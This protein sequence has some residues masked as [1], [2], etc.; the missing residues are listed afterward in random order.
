MAEYTLQ[1]EHKSTF[2]MLIVQRGLERY[3]TSQGYA[4]LVELAAFI[5]DDGRDDGAIYGGV[6]GEIYF[7]WLYVDLLWVDQS[8]RGQRC[9][10]GLMAAVEREA[11]ARGVLGAYLATTSFQAL[12]FYQHLGYEVFAQLEDRPAGHAYYY[13]SKPGPLEPV[14][15]DDS[16]LT[17]IEEP[18]YND[19]LAVRQG[20]KAFNRSQNVDVDG[21]RLSVFLRDEVGRPRGGL[22][23]AVYWDWLDIQTIWLDETLRGQGYGAKLLARAEQEAAAQGCTG[24]VI[25]VPGAASAGFFERRGYTLFGTLTDRPPGEF[26]RFLR[27]TLI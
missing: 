23:G 3:Y 22:L 14:A 4:P 26:T 7:G 5:R 24:A 17:V 8:R 18:E 12:P 6:D 10:A 27:K 21:Q 15:G 9:G 11:A 2:D 1:V 19:V 20:L 16:D 25:E 13:L